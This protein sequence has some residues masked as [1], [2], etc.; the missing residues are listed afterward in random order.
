VNYGDTPSWQ[1]NQWLDSI[2]K[3]FWV[4]S[5]TPNKCNPD[6]CLQGVCHLFDI[7]DMP[8]ITISENLELLDQDSRKVAKF[9]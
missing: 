7:Q 4:L 6:D 8:N 3:V 2:L 1:L 5:A 9:F